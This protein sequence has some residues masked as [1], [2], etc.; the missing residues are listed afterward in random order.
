MERLLLSLLDNAV[1]YTPAGGR[2][3]VSAY[4]D[5]RH[6]I[7]EIRTRGLA[8]TIAIYRTSSIASIAPTELARAKYR[9]PDSA[10]AIARW[11]ADGHN[12]TIEV[13][14]FVGKG[15]AVSSSGA[16]CGLGNFRGNFV[17]N[18]GKSRGIR[19]L[20]GQ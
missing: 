18:S 16:A 13:R 11:I 15:C 1:K 2:V 7:V 19:C 20:K 17:E 9:D 14:E 6:A 8:L 4:S 5:E 3:S 10:L 12:A